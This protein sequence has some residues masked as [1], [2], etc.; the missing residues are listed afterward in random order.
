MSH[1]I[2]LKLSSWENLYS[3]WIIILKEKSFSFHF[4]KLETKLKTASNESRFELSM[5]KLVDNEQ[6]IGQKWSTIFHVWFLFIKK[7]KKKFNF[8]DMA[9]IWMAV[10]F[11]NKFSLI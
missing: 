3:K 1:I 5:V 2:S 9:V 7:K 6:E 10:T 11:F 4:I 8:Y